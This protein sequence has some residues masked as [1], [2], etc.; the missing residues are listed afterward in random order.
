MLGDEVGDGCRGADACGYWSMFLL[1]CMQHG[2][3]LML[4]LGPGM[5]PPGGVLWLAAAAA[6]DGLQSADHLLFSWDYVTM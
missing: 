5:P 6:D 3:Q 4:L 2:V 1:E